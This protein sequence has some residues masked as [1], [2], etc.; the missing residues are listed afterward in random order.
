MFTSTLGFPTSPLNGPVRFCAALKAER[1]PQTRRVNPI[2]PSPPPP[3]AVRCLIVFLSP[4]TPPFFS[5]LSVLAGRSLAVLP[6]LFLFPSLPVGISGDV[7]T[8]RDRGNFAA[9]GID[10]WGRAERGGGGWGTHTEVGEP[11]VAPLRCWGRVRVCVRAPFLPG[12]LTLGGE[13]WD[14]PPPSPQPYRA[15]LVCTNRAL[16]GCSA[17]LGES[18]AKGGV[19]GGGGE[20]PSRRGFCCVGRC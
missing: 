18:W 11:G 10:S 17:L 9:M 15:L 4:P 7:N 3:Q 19:C 8:A 16:W 2:P 6:P 5:K 14:P 1:S 12:S 20:H 13:K